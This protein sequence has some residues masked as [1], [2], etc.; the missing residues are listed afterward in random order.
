M[1]VQFFGGSVVLS[2][3]C[4]DTVTPLPNRSTRASLVLTHISLPG[5][6]LKTGALSGP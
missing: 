4:S 1:S 5:R 6:N 3:P 2:G